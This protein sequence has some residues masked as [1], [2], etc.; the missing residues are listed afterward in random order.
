MSVHFARQAGSE[1]MHQEGG[2]VTAG[3]KNAYSSLW[4]VQKLSAGGLGAGAGART[5]ARARAGSAPGCYV[6][7][8]SAT[9][10]L[11]KAASHI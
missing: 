4:L 6:K 7:S 8:A 10:T 11:R 3:D 2:R 1:Q 9:T 5:R